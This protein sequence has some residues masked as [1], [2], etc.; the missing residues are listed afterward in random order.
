MLI[1]SGINDC[2]IIVKLLIY[3]NIIN[4]RHIKKVETREDGRPKIRSYWLSIIHLML[5]TFS[6]LY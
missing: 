2:L 6:L 4:I 3:S 5:F 1:E